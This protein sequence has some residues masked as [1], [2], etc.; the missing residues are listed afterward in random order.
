MRHRFRASGCTG[1]L[2]AAVLLAGC[3]TGTDTA[4]HRPLAPILTGYS[5]TSAIDESGVATSTQLTSAQG[6]TLRRAI[7]SLTVI[8]ASH[9]WENELLFKLVIA[10]PSRHG[11]AW[12]ATALLCPVPGQI[13]VNGTTRFATCS[14]IA[15]AASYLPAGTS[16]ACYPTRA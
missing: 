11:A 8:P 5:K 9:C 10:A 14:V 13:V 7:Q 1:V 16:G 15:L 3:G 4:Q 6:A 2:L 12:T